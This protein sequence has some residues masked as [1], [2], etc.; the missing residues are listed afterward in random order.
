MNASTPYSVL[1]RRA[2]DSTAVPRLVDQ[3]GAVVLERLARAAGAT[4]WFFIRRPDQLEALAGRLSPGSSVSFYFD[5]RIKHTAFDAD[6]AEA[7]LRFAAEDGDAVVGRLSADEI[8]IEVEIVAGRSD[9]DDFAE[10]LVPGQP[11]FAGRFPARDDD[12]VRAV[13]LDLPDRDGIVR[14]HPH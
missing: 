14:P 4:R 11:V 5:D 9:L 10:S 3:H 7:I 13:T 6:V 8:E 12:A 2:I 1:A